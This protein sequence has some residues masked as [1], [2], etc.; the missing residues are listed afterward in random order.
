MIVFK[1][2]F[3]ILKANIV[4]LLI[5][6][7]VFVGFAVFMSTF[8]YKNTE[9]TAVVP[10]IAIINK[11]DNEL[12]K[13]FLDYVEKRANIKDV[14][15]VNDA[16]FYRDIEYALFIEE[17]FNIDSKINSMSI[18]NSTSS[19]Y[20]EMLF[21]RYL[22]VV[23]TYMNNGIDLETSVKLASADLEYDSKVMIESSGSSDLEL[24][25]YFFNFSNYSILAILIFSI[26]TV[27]MAFKKK[28]IDY[29]NKISSMK[30]QS[31]NNQMFLASTVF[32]IFVFIFVNIMAL[33]L[34]TDGYMKFNS[35]FM[36]LNLFVFMITAISFSL[37]IANLVKSSESLI[38]IVNIT[39]LGSSFLSGAFVPQVFLGSFVVFVSKFFFS[40]YFI[41]NNNIIA[42]TTNINFSNLSEYF[43]NLLVMIIFAIL[44][45]LLNN[46]T[47]KRKNS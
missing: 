9:F 47:T 17:D 29:K 15:E 2:Y 11:S 12:T 25:S 26:S 36:I 33:I 14:S 10:N 18:P 20:I 35:L 37:F 39:A 41:S 46:F 28:Y 34:F 27:T 7:V 30:Y 32:S 40:Y 13:G 19:I 5:Y 22:N 45:Y 1:N 31:I 24:M 8:G 42:Y 43:F 23:A 16:L 4:S 44:F 3:K 21:N 38:G 6:V